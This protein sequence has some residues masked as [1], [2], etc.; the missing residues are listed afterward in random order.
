M[1]DEM[2]ETHVGI[3]KNVKTTFSVVV[4]IN[5]KKSAGIEPEK[6]MLY[7]R[8]ESPKHRLFIVIMLSTLQYCYN[9]KNVH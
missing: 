4:V 1:S 3:F 2:K 9:D 6:R 8:K 5:V 7:V